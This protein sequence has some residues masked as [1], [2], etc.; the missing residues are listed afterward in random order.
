MTDDFS[1]EY[2]TTNPSF[3]EKF[4]IPNLPISIR[5]YDGVEISRVYSDQWGTFDGLVSSTWE[6]NP[7]NPTGYA[8]GVMVMC[9]NHRGPIPGPNGTMITDPNDNPNYSDFCHEVVIHAHRHGV[10]GYAIGPDR[11][12]CRRLHPRDRSYPDTIL[13][14]TVSRV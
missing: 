3:G 6:V 9:T 14:S 4:A 2:D 12:V 10:S 8:P 13:R 5:D 7:P 1:S 11:C